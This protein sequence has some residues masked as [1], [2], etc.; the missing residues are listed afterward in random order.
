MSAFLAPASVFLKVEISGGFSRL[1]TGNSNPLVEKFYIYISFTQLGIRAGDQDA[2]LGSAL[3]TIGFLWL[4]QRYP[5]MSYL[6]KD[7]VASFWD[8]TFTSW[9]NLTF[10]KFKCV[11]SG[12]LVNDQ[13]FESIFKNTLRSSLLLASDVVPASFSLPSLFLSSNLITLFMPTCSNLIKE[14]SPASHA[15]LKRFL[16]RLNF[17]DHLATQHFEVKLLFPFKRM[18]KV[19][20]STHDCISARPGQTCIC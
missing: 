2:D 7:M 19:R 9:A 14:I 3:M 1:S 20:Q 18:K 4:N 13:R 10:V 6:N 12:T 16:H 11:S 5:L 15:K 8:S 17:R